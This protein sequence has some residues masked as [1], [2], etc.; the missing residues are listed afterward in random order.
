MISGMAA[1]YS[2]AGVFGYGPSSLSMGIP[3][4]LLGQ[5]LGALPATIL[6]AVLGGWGGFLFE[7]LP[8]LPTKGGGACWGLLYALSMYLLLAGLGRLLGGHAFADYEVLTTFYRYLTGSHN[9][10]QDFFLS[11]LGVFLL[12][13]GAGT[14]GGAKLAKV[15][16]TE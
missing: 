4:F 3:I 7:Q 15:A 9:V 2:L 5:L 13:L 6:G 1:F 16:Y 12:Y 11:S 10:N 14:W 8:I